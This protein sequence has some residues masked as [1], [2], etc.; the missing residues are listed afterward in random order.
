MYSTDLVTDASSNA[1][2]EYG[3]DFICADF[4]DYDDPMR[5]CIQIF[6]HASKERAF[7]GLTLA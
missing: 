1:M 7:G 5:A 6:D 3:I 2:K 4:I